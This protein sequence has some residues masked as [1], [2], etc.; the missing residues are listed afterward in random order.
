[1]I[2]VLLATGL[3]PPEIGGPATYAKMLQEDLPDHDINLTVVPFS[4]VRK[5][6]KI[7]RH[8]MYFW[9]L[10]RA[11]KQADIVYALDPISVGLPAMF[12][13]KLRRNKFILRVG[14]DYAWEQGRVRFG[15]TETL[16]EYISGKS[17]RPMSVR[18]LAYIQ[19][20]VAKQAVVIVAPSNYLKSIVTQW[21][22]AHESVQ[23]I[24]STLFPLIPNESRE[25][26]RQVL[27]LGSPVL[28]T[29]GRLVPW[30]GVDTVIDVASKM[31]DTHP[32][33]TLVVVGDGPERQVL[34]SKV[35]KYNLDK[36]VRFVGRQNKTQLANII[37]AADVFILN[38]AYEGLSH[39][40]LEVMEL[41]VPI[42][43]TNVGGNPELLTDGVDATL[44]DFDDS[45]ALTKACYRII[46]DT[47]HA[48]GLARFAKTRTADF[49]RSPA[50][51]QILQLLQT[52]YEES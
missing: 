28:V 29:S 2:Q 23:V 20:W 45:Y 34:E 46:D 9:K 6:P 26:T 41:G 36:T 13:A 5:Y 49:G 4:T 25:Q 18:L 7:I 12:V 38:T 35:A 40:L 16:D 42:V 33:V 43:T 17:Y 39:Q 14:G 52:V 31:Q 47:Q 37:N 30:K 21:G 19:A 44:V 8:V 11:A 1:M 32:D 22:I 24:Y 27:S 48:S 15:V 3:Y 51:D 10:F 50:I